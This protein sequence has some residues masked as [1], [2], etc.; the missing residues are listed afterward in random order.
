M[1]TDFTPG[2]L[3]PDTTG[4]HI[5]AHG[6]GLLHHLGTYYW[7]GEHKIA[8]EAGN[9]AHVGVSVYAS[10]DLL[11]WRPLGVALTVSDDPASDI[12]RGCVLE[13]P[14][15]LFCAATGKFVMWFH[16]ELKGQGYR[17]ARV[18]VATADRPEGPYT[19]HR[20]FRPNAGL[21]PENLPP[22]SR[23]PLS[24][25]EFQRLS[26]ARGSQPGV[27]TD[28]FLRR[29][30]AGGQ[31]SRDMTLFLDEGDPAAGIPPRAYHLTAS[32]ENATLHLSEL[33]PDFLGTTGRY[34]R[35][36]PGRS[37]E[38][39]ALFKHNGRYFLI[40]SDCTGWAPN[41]ARLSTAPSLWGPWTELG[42]PCRGTP[43]Q[44]AVTF[45]SQST[46]VL[47][48]AG[49]PGAFIFLADRW[50]PQDAIDGRYIWLP[51]LWDGDRPYLQWFDAWNLSV[52][53]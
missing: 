31:M 19:F 46:Y 33:T 25:D 8:G 20:S 7:F 1:P 12:T 4:T 32:E 38:A 3:W 29:D 50:R 13:R 5:N 37:H 14:K 22:E 36:F 41:P 49:K 6:G 18:G 10:T 23:Q 39:P 40:S 30:F 9:Q 16:L 28:L 17:A 26:L 45:E 21:W 2:T 11:N 15:V 48:V 43:E 51:V 47:P 24:P 35:L 44:V 52:F 53:G 42:N 27:P 34:I